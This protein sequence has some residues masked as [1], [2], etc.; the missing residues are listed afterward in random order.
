MLSTDKDQKRTC[1]KQDKIERPYI[2]EYTY[3]LN[4]TKGETEEV[5]YGNDLEDGWSK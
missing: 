1:L 4:Q 2:H 3:T 5:P